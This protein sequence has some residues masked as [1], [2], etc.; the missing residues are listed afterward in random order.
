MPYLCLVLQDILFTA[1]DLFK[2]EKLE[3]GGVKGRV[4]SQHVQ[5]L[6]Q[7]FGET[8]K[9]FTEK[10]YNCLDLNNKVGAIGKTRSPGF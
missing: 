4:L 1:V 7:D 9:L 2:L 6:H 8:Y 3:I 5:L 10:P